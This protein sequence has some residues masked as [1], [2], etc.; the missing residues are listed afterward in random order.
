VAAASAADQAATKLQEIER[1][2]NCKARALAKRHDAAIDENRRQAA[3]DLSQTRSSLRD[4]NQLLT[5]QLASARTTCDKAITKLGAMELKWE[6]EMKPNVEAAAAMQVRFE[7]FAAREANVVR[8]EHEMHVLKTRVGQLEATL[9]AHRQNNEHRVELHGHRTA[10]AKLV[11]AQTELRKANTEVTTMRNE[12]I[13]L[14]SMASASA[15]DCAGRCANAAQK[16]YAATLYRLKSDGTRYDPYV[17]ECMRRLCEECKI[18]FEAA[19]TAN[20]I[21]LQMHMRCEKLTDDLL[22]KSNFVAD[23][24]IRLGVFDNHLSKMARDDLHVHTAWAIGADGGNKGREIDMIMFSAWDPQSGKAVAIP[25]AAADLHSDQAA[26]HLAETLKKAAGSSGFSLAGCIQVM[27]DGASA[28][29]GEKGEAQ[30]FLNLARSAS[31]GDTGAPV[32]RSLKETCAIH[33][34]VLE[35]KHAMEAAF[36]GEVLCNFTRLIWECF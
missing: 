32:H 9:M 29:S 3:L 7:G 21:I 20:A 34:K 5:V 23:S 33:G 26:K 25:G 22:L 36:P 11:A 16:T 18:T 12:V 17:V 2:Y 4:D 6:Q 10:N 28:C 19:A 14:K 27:T 1:E 8:T 15:R 30:L 13:A 24:Y 35:E 31:A